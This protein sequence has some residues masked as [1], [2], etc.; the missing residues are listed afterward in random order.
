MY[1]LLPRLTRHIRS[2][3]EHHDVPSREAAIEMSALLYSLNLE[4]WIHD[5]STTDAINIIPTETDELR[6]ITTLSYEFSTISLYTLLIFY[7]CARVNLLG[8][9]QTLLGILEEPSLFDI[10]TIWNQ[11]VEAATSLAMSV[12]YAQK[13]TP[14]PFATAV[15]RLVTLP[16]KC[17]FGSWHRLERRS[18]EGSYD[19]TRAKHMKE[20]TTSF[21]NECAKF[22]RGYGARSKEGYEVVAEVVSGEREGQDWIA[23]SRTWAGRRDV[24]NLSTS[25]DRRISRAGPG[26]GEQ[27]IESNIC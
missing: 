22:Q 7:W 6:A 15:H 21:C 8:L 20:W 10:S 25:C 23:T 17:V 12:Q 14:P 3:M 16:L 24:F 2:M 9:C 27:P 5:L 19:A 18:P 1:I 26:L 13:A 4:S 11:D